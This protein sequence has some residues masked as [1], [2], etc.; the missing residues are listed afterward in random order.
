MT[1]LVEISIQLTLRREEREARDAAAT[2]TVTISS[3]VISNR[4]ATTQ[5]NVIVTTTPETETAMQTTTIVVGIV[6]SAMAAVKDLSNK[7]ECEESLVI[8]VSV[9][10]AV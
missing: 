9:A 7:L 2:I 8:A 6:T 4:T 5:T 1:T 3:P 10:D